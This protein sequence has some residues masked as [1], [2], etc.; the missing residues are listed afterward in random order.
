M[1]KAKEKARVKAKDKYRD[2][3]KTRNFWSELPK[4]TSAHQ[5]FSHLELPEDSR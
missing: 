2:S 3:A 1:D 5:E 4:C